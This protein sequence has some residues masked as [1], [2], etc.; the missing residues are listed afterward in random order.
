MEKTRATTKQ[1]LDH[2]AMKNK[3]VLA[4]KASKMIFAV[5]SDAGYCN[6][7][8]SRSRAGGHFFLS[9]D[10][11][12]PPNNGAIL[13]IATIIK[14]VMSS[15]VEAELGALYLNAKERAYLRQI[16]AE[17]DHPQPQTPIQ[18]NNSMAKGVINHKIQPKQTKSMDVH[19]HWLC[20]H[21]AQGQFCIYWQ[22]GKL[23]SAN[24]FTKHHSPLHH[25]NVRNEFLLKAKELTEA[26]SQRLTQGQTP[27]NSA[28]SRLATRV[29]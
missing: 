27:P 8:K 22:P 26:R 10:D 24:Y 12:F 19:F 13:T 6:K 1:L 28:T 2:C 21:K 25:F 11:D 9:N 4:Y 17:M 7:K 3:A 23:N 20:Y 14:A 16:L 18:T 15:A 29:C 5:H